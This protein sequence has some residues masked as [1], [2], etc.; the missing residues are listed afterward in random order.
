MGFNLKQGAKEQESLLTDSYAKQRMRLKGQQNATTQQIGQN[1]DRLQARTG[2]MGGSIEKARNKAYTGVAKEFADTEAALGAEEAG[3]LA[4]LKG[5]QQE[6]GLQESQFKDT[7]AMQKKQFADTMKYQWAEMDEN[8]KTNLVNATI[9]IK[10]SG[11]R[12]PWQF[13]TAQYGGRISGFAKKT[14][15]SRKAAQ[16]KPKPIAWGVPN[17]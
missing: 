16:P 17:A 2:A 4:S 8:K 14:E 3:Q 1:V 7:M 9:A 5:R 12:D 15:A 10:E 11:L 13:L 6:L